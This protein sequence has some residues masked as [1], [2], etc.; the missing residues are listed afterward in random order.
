MGVAGEEIGAIG[1]VGALANDP[2][3]APG[4]RERIDSADPLQLSVPTLAALAA[5][6]VCDPFGV[7]HRNHPA[8][9]TRRARAHQVGQPGMSVGHAQD[10]L[11]DC[12]DPGRG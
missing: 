8:V 6:K 3:W 11:S 9:A 7:D 2:G 12:L 10:P 4:T 1:A 5:E